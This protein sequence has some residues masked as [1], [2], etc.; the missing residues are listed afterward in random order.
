[1][2]SPYQHLTFFSLSTV[3]LLIFTFPDYR[4]ELG[5]KNFYQVLA[6]LPELMQLFVKVHIRFKVVI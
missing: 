1:V 3:P 5:G 6:R 4:K 2:K